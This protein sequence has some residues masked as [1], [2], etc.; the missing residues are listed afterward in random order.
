MIIGLIYCHMVV[1]ILIG[2]LFGYIGSMPVAGPIALLV[3]RLG[4]GR[5]ARLAKYVAMGGALAESFYAAFAFWG[6]SEILDRHPMILPSTRIAGACIC[7]GLGIILLL[8]RAKA[9]VEDLRPER[10]RGHKRS[11]L[12]GFL[13]TALN[14]TLLITWTTALATLH[15]T[16]LVTLSLHGAVPFAVGVFLGVVGW[17]ATLLGMV[18]R[19]K[20]RFSSK[21]VEGFIHVMGGFLVL[22]ALWLG[23]RALIH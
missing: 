19:F 11:F 9:P 6:V 4:L 5:D 12:G 21:A 22:L 16:G 3:L 17:F 14:P 10:R 15:S 18:K 8:H 1:S 20:E 2:F 23:A 13:I 7:M